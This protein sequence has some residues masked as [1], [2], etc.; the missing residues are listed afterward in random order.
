MIRFLQGLNFLSLALL[1]RFPSQQFRLLVLR[2]IF[3]ARIGP[4]AVLYGRFEIRSPRNLKIGPKTVVGHRATLDARG[5][6][7]IGKNVNLSSEVMIWTAQHDYRDPMFGTVFKPVFVG[8]YAWL[9][10]RCIILPGV[11]IGEG[12]VVAAGAVV[13]KDVEPYTVVGGIPAKKI[14]DRS[15][16]LKYDPAGNPVPLI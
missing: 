2:T 16:N 15:R 3:G 14:A 4:S 8:D 12:A 6:L 9:G 13:S 10:P 7:T 11:S 1:A 5:G